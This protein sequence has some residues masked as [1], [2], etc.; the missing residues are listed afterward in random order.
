VLEA[1]L[2]WVAEPPSS[3]SSSSI[4]VFWLA[5]LAGTGKST[6]AKTFCKRVSGDKNFLLASFFASR[7]SVERRDP[8]SI[9]HT[10]AYDLAVT[11]DQ[12]RPHI[13]CAVRAPQD[14]TQQPMRE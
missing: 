2:S 11:S 9:L 1:V 5:G 14:I 12:L 3:S 8:Y 4:S 7:N 13:L 10:F 6:I